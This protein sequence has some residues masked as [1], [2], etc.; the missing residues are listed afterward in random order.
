MDLLFKYYSIDERRYSVSNLY[1]SVV[2]YNSLFTFNDPF[3]GIGRVIYN[4]DQ[5]NNDFWEAVESNIVLNKKM[6]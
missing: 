1:K 2:V 5:P 3:E 4:E 6:N